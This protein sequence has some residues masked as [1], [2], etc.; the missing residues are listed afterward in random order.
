LGWQILEKMAKAKN[1]LKIIT[2]ITKNLTSRPRLRSGLFLN[3]LALACFAEP[4]PL[5]AQRQSLTIVPAS[6]V[7]GPLICK[8]GFG[9]FQCWAQAFDTA[10]D[11]AFQGNGFGTQ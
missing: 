4:T 10:N 8:P 9:P 6:P 7:T 11:L 2:K 1:T 3:L 5:P